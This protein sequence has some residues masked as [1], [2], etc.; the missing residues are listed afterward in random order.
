MRYKLKIKDQPE[1][2]F[3]HVGDFRALVA[4]A[5]FRDVQ[6]WIEYDGQWE[7]LPPNGVQAVI[8]ND[9]F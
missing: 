9:G 4:E 6:L 2:I 7:L 5:C 8:V 1:Q 3:Q